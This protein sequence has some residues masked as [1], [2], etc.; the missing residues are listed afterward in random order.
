[1]PLEFGR[2]IRQYT[3]EIIASGDECNI[4][5]SNTYRTYRHAKSEMKAT[6]FHKAYR[7]LDFLF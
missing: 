7:T 5:M 1:M 4:G 6:F 2:H 3:H